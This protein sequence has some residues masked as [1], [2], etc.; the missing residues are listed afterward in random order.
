MRLC[1]HLDQ[2]ALSAIDILR[3]NDNATVIRGKKIFG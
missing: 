1:W 3:Q 2:T